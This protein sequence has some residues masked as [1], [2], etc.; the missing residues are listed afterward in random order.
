MNQKDFIDQVHMEI[1]A[2]RRIGSSYKPSN[3]EKNISRLVLEYFKS[4]C[5]ECREID[6]KIKAQPQDKK[7]AGFMSRIKN[8][9]GDD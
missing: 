7:S 3:M 9:M 4:T 6:E 5:K 1:H 8:A 2:V